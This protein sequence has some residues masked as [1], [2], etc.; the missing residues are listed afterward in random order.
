MIQIKEIDPAKA[1]LIIA[2]E[3]RERGGEWYVNAID[4]E[5]FI[6]ARMGSRYADMLLRS[7]SPALAGPFNDKWKLSFIASDLR[8]AQA[9]SRYIKPRPVDSL[10]ITEDSAAARMAKLLQRGPMT[11]VAAAN[12]LGIHRRTALTAICRLVN[13]GMARSSGRVVN[14]GSGRNPY[15]YE[16]A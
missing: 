2:D 6:M 5:G 16:A 12:I 11:A 15:L 1:S 14:G 8:E 9:L 3:L 7:G 4:A 10:P 13:R